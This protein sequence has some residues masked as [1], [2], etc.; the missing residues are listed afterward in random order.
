MMIETRIRSRLWAETQLQHVTSSCPEQWTPHLEAQVWLPTRRILG[1]LLSRY[2]IFKDMKW[3][4]RCENQLNKRS[5]QSNGENS[6]CR[7]IKMKT[8]VLQTNTD[9]YL[10][11]AGLLPGACVPICHKRRSSSAKWKSLLFCLE[12][13]NAPEDLISSWHANA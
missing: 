7:H 2:L 8:N 1:S 10:S 3:R 5:L 11:R 6:L 4:I 12:S 9:I 13:S